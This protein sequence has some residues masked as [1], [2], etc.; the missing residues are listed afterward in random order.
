MSPTT[1][2]SAT[3]PGDRADQP[4]LSVRGLT[5]DF[6]VGGLLSRRRVRAL[7]SVDLDIPR[8]RIV[9]LVGE[10]GSGKSTIARC[11]IRLERPTA[12]RI[13]LDGEDVTHG[14]RRRDWHAYRGRV[15]MV[16]QDP[17]GS[18]NPVHRVE[19]FLTRALLV[20]DRAHGRERLR[21]RLG[22]LMSTVGLAE[23]MLQSYPH[24]LS[25]GQRQRVAIARALAV[26][27]QVILADEPT[28]MLDVSVRIGIL[29][30]MRR[31]RDE[32][33]IS[34]LY[35]THDLASARYVADTTMVMFAGELVEG[36]DSLALMARPAHP[37][38]RLLLSAVPDPERAGGY[39][40]V[41]RA[42]LRAAVLS[43]TSCPY[44]GDPGR[45]CSR[46]EPVRHLVGED[47]GQPHWVRCHLYAPAVPTAPHA[48][49]A[50]PDAVAD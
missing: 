15:Q 5:K 19:H 40:P 6:P 36:G 26:D 22:E 2:A 8:G 3:R 39:D 7:N 25:G 30:L 10:S 47:D 21:H 41:E 50:G 34:M 16:F 27:P 44:Q 38:T 18:L 14:R 24:E 9:A 28:S 32:R 23:E 33:G 37:Y 31:L 42:R 35:I 13:L 46:T 48:L 1:A 11:L 43:A 45:P 29:N 12:G 4:L 20:H 17:F 49:S